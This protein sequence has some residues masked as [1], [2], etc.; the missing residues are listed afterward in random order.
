MSYGYY[1][2]FLLPL[3]SGIFF[4]TGTAKSDPVIIDK[5]TMYKNPGTYF[6][7][8]VLSTQTRIKYGKVFRLLSCME[9]G[10]IV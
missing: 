9:C 10:L 1:F 2:Y 5:L 3:G 7:L 4:H 8:F 6:Y